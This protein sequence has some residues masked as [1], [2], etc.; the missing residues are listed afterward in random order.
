M[1][2]LSS[3][4]STSIP[5]PGRDIFV[6]AWYQG[7]ISVIDFT[8]SAN[9]VEIAYFDRGP[10]DPEALVVGGYWSTYWYDGRIFGT[11]IVR[12]LDVLRLLPSEFLSE[13]EVAAANLAD[14]GGVFNPQQ[15][16]PA[17]WPAEPVVARAYL[18]QLSGTD[19]L[20]AGFAADVAR[21]LTD[22]TARLDEGVNDKGLA[23]KL[24]S[25]AASLQERGRDA[26]TSERRLALAETLTGI[27]ARL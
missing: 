8:D 2:S 19:A 3:G 14:Q 13:E 9:P 7:G 27:A 10:V 26:I 23:R 20:P 22:A 4:E 12:G 5:V 25:L 15:Q 16:F 21:A 17:R 24:E 6:Q 11:E 18:N 1:M